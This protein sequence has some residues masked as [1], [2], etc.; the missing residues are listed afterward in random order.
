[1]ETFKVISGHELN[2]LKIRKGIGKY[3][4]E[5]S[6]IKELNSCFSNNL[7]YIEYN[8]APLDHDLYTSMNLLENFKK[9]NIYLYTD[10]KIKLE[11]ISNLEL[12]QKYSQIK[13]LE[14]S[15]P[16]FVNIKMRT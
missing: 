15:T 11:I 5:I 12:K 8:E 2:P 16:I 9:S 14:Y 13:V 6:F 3:D 7:V 1:M 10:S 4:R